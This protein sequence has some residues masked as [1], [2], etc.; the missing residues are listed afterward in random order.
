MSYD[1]VEVL[2]NH[3]CFLVDIPLQNVFPEGSNKLTRIAID[4][5]LQTIFKTFADKY[6]LKEEL[7][8]ADD[9]FIAKYDATVPD[10]QR[11]LE[12]HQDKHLFSFVL[13]L[14]ED[15]TEG[16]TYFFSTG[17]LWRPST[18]RAVLFHGMHWHAGE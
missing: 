5:A 7:I 3:S 4:E 16:G 17:E 13:A 15:F 18:G 2:Q 1:A 11:H 9:L 8:A 6:Q 10:R 12:P 14:N